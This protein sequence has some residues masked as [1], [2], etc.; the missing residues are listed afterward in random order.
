MSVMEQLMEKSRISR[1]GF[2]QAAGALS[3][4]AALYGCGGGDGGENSKIDNATVIPK[5]NLV[6]DK[7]MKTVMQCHPFN[8]G[9]RCT[10]KFHVKNGRML[11]LTSAGDIPRA[12]AETSDERLDLIQRRA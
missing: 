5:D 6:M 1:R 8:C 9:S 7:E 2:L 4:T 10:F 11:K 3:A 12:G